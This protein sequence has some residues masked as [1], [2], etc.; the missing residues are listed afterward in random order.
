MTN[1]DT[2][3]IDVVPIPAPVV[4]A[5]ADI[6]TVDIDNDAAGSLPPPILP[7]NDDDETDGVLVAVPL[8]GETKVAT[9]IGTPQ[10]PQKSPPSGV[11]IKKYDQCIISTALIHTLFTI[12]FFVTPFLIAKYHS[13]E[14]SDGWAGLFKAIFGI[15][16]MGT[17]MLVTTIVMLCIGGCR[18]N[19]LSTRMKVL[20]FYP[21]IVDVLLIAV[22]W[23]IGTVNVSESSS[24]SSVGGPITTFETLAPTSAPNF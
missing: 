10:P 5:T 1:P 20:T 12:F 6:E 18:W 8:G 2:S 4:K 17:A 9:V 22:W 14:G 13:T 19:T 16:I 11:V 15:L 23:I 21:L 24:S 7:T 3:K